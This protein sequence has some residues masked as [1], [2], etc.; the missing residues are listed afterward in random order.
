MTYSV[1]N[2]L[3]NW[4]GDQIEK[5]ETDLKRDG[6]LKVSMGYLESIRKLAI[7]LTEVMKYN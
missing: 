3:L 6:K 2:L 5:A 7:A 1:L 4:C